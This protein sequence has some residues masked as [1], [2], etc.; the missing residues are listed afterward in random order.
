[1]IFA[2]DYLSSCVEKYIISQLFLPPVSHQQFLE[3]INH[4]MNSVPLTDIQIDSSASNI[5]FLQPEYIEKAAVRI[6]EIAED[7]IDLF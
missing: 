7:T 1:M 5:L 2:H 6:A 3:I 4:N